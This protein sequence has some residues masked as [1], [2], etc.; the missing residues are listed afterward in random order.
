[1]LKT[2]RQVTREDCEESALLLDPDDRITP[3]SKRYHLSIGRIT[4][5]VGKHAL[6]LRPSSAHPSLSTV[7]RATVC[8]ALGGLQALQMVENVS[9]W[10]K[11]C[12]PSGLFKRM[13]G[14][15]DF[16]Y[17]LDM[18]KPRFNVLKQLRAE[19]RPRN[20]RKRSTRDCRLRY[21]E[22]ACF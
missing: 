8:G 22:G 13:T 11:S 19:K 21:Y 20:E 16:S 15:N 5:L 1:M 2:A 7:S 17:R 12:R 14:G 9:P 3:V 6:A 4:T 10:I 18:R